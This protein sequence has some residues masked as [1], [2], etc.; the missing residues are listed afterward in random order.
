MLI[1]LGYDLR[2]ELPA[3]TA[4]IA[5]LHVHPSREADLLEPDEIVTEPGLPLTSYIDS[6]G[7][8]CTR[9]YAPAGLL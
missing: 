5:L 6:F 8:R 2:F 1:R 9:L 3:P 7:N 4:L